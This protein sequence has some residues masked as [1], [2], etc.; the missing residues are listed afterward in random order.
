LQFFPKE[1]AMIAVK[2]EKSPVPIVWLD[3]SV[4]TKMTLYKTNPEKLDKTQQSRIVQL[5]ELIRSA[6]RDGKVICPLGGQEMEVWIDRDAWMD[7]IHDLG[8]GI[9]CASE[10][11]IQE[12]QMRSAISAYLEGSPELR[13][14]YL[15]A[16]VGD[17]VHELKQVLGQPFF[18]AVRRDI[19]FGADYHRKKNPET[20]ELLNAAREKNVANKISLEKQLETERLGELKLLLSQC[21]EV[22]NSQEGSKDESAFWGYMD[23]SNRVRL[24]A[25]LGGSPSDIDGYIE[26]YKSE[27]NQKSPQNDLAATLYAKIMV[28]PQP[29][30]SG[31]PM[32]IVHIST[33]MP[34]SD[35][36][37]TDKAWSTFLNRNGIANRYGTTVCFIGDTDV[38]TNFFNPLVR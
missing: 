19:L 37:I 33:L 28:D 8:F 1:G 15:D 23:M 31:D 38:I 4:I 13:L 6:S 18:V 7:T 22:I 36:F 34:Y 29:I 5:Y 11:T 14:S 12:N 27:Y 35:L 26:F 9:E 30:R 21:A 17:P 25:E 10:K 32:D 2:I 3:T 24:W 16:F 20:L